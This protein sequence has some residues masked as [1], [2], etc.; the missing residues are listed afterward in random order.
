MSELINAG[1]P[2]SEGFPTGPS[3]GE[4]VPDFVLPDHLGN[5]VRFSDARGNGQALILFYRS[6][7]W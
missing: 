7:S 5:T 3:I 6:A 1:D 2:V 4:A